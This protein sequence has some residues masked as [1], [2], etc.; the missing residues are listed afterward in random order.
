MALAVVYGVCERV[1]CLSG[2]L[3]TEESGISWYWSG[4][5]EWMDVQ[6][7]VIER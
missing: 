4:A 3:G 1:L 5:C 6:L 7:L 2:V